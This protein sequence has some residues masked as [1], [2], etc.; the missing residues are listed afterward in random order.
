MWNKIRL[1]RTYMLVS[2]QRTPPYLRKTD[3]PLPSII[4]SMD[5]GFLLV[6]MQRYHGSSRVIMNY[7]SSLRAVYT[8]GF[9]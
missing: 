9:Y 5:P 3:G 4:T 7:F 2:Y 1:Y 6:L 8:C